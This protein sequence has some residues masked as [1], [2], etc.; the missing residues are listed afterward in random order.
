MGRPAKSIRIK[1]GKI[2]NEE[3]ENREKTEN[4]LKGQND[5]IRAPTYLTKKQKNIFKY[6]VNELNNSKIL[7]NLDV[8]MLSQT[9]IAIDRIQTIENEINEDNELLKDSK[10]M[11]TKEKYSKEF[12]RC[13][14]ELCLSP[15]ARAKISINFKDDSEKKK[16]LADILEED[17]DN[18]KE[19][20]DF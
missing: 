1:T 2:S 13:C 15:Q 11:A 4:N 19:D 9:A 20:F 3:I 8:Y 6:I 18:D 14:N 5:K 16:T 10:Y 12:F 7:G 17:D